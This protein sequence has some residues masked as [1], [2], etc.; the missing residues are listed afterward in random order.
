VLDARDQVEALLRSAEGVAQLRGSGALQDMK[1]LVP[2]VRLLQ[3]GVEAELC[4]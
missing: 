1:R 3:A 4:S 2:N